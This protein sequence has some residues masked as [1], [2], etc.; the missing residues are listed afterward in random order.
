MLNAC[1]M[2]YS[3][4]YNLIKWHPKIVSE[5]EN[6]KTKKNWGRHYSKKHLEAGA[7]R[8]RELPTWHSQENWAHSQQCGRQ[9]NDDAIYTV[10]PSKSPEFTLIDTAGNC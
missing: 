9:R 4:F 1:I 3:S 5:L 10:E 8:H 6:D 7:E 2:F